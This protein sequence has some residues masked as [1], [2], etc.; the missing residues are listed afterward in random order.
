MNRKSL[1]EKL[2]FG[3]NTWDSH[4]M[5]S[6]SH[7][8]EGFC[9]DLMLKD[10]SCDEIG[11]GFQV[12]VDGK[13]NENVRIQPRTY[14]GKYIE[15]DVTWAKTTVNVRFTSDGEDMILLVT[16]VKHGLKSS[17]LIVNAGILWGREG[18][19]GKKDDILYGETGGK[20]FSVYVS[21]ERVSL[22]HA[23]TTTPYIAVLLKQAVVISNRQISE[24]QALI[25]LDNARAE[26]E[27]RDE[28]FGEKREIM[29]AMRAC[30]SWNTIFEPEMYGICTP[31]NRFWNLQWGGYVIFPW[32]GFFTAQMIAVENPELAQA[33]TISILDGLLE[34]GFLPNFH[35]ANGYISMDRSNPPVGSFVCLDIYRL[36]DDIEYLQCVYPKLLRWNEWFAQER[37]NSEGYLRWG[38]YPPVVNTGKLYETYDVHTSRGAT[39]ESGMDL[40][41]IYSEAGF[42][43]ETSCM[44]MADVALMSLYVL[45]CKALIEMSE[46]LGSEDKRIEERLNKV[47]TTLLSMWDDDL[48]IFANYHLDTKRASGIVGPTGILA[49]LS[50][51]V[52]DNQKDTIVKKWL[53]D[54]MKLGGTFSLPTVSRDDDTYHPEETLFRGRIWPPVNYLVYLALRNAGLDEEAQILANKSEDLFLKEWR[55]HRHVHE[56]HHADTGNGDLPGSCPLYTWGGLH[57]YIAWDS[58]QRTL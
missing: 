47:Q 20:A 46:I 50:D 45:D 37:M 14:D 24:D 8:P 44:T 23:F 39:Y 52:T 30:L 56:N 54:P 5:L 32:D 17:A 2:A 10:Y 27:K 7:L 25:M 57:A 40:A 41:S 13:N 11:H 28:R 12:C 43:D 18:A 33:N 34:E 3:W 49:L 51:G 36:T 48:G 15:L 1:E 4:S 16:P 38:S 53:N 21:G 35:S 22:P 19:V 6:F 42:D 55:E 29:A 31:V 58:Y 26:M 9:I